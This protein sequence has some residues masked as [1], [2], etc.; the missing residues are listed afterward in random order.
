MA[1]RYPV[2]KLPHSVMRRLLEAH[3]GGTSEDV[4]V[5]PAIGEDAAALQLDHLC[6]VAASDPI[7]FATEAIGY[8]AVHVN[9][10]D[11]ATMGARP[12]WFL[13]TLLIPPVATD[14]EIEKIFVDIASACG[15]IG[16]AWCG[17]HTEICT[18]LPRPLVVG[19][20]LGT[21]EEGRLLCTADAAAGDLLFCTKRVPLEATA[22]I[23]RERREWALRQLGKAAWQR[24]SEL[25][26][27]PGISVVAEAVAA[28]A[29]GDALHDPTEGGIATGLH[30]LADAASVGLEIDFA[31]IPFD[32]DGALLCTA[33]SID[34]LGALASGALLIA[35]P[36]EQA[37]CVSLA[38]ADAGVECQLIGRLVEK[39][40]GR[41]LRRG[42]E[43]RELPAFAVDEVARL[44]GSANQGR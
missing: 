43:R 9:A 11:V 10:N 38:V 34:P 32:P 6:L 16:A 44:F 14:G 3:V 25:L 22:L 4:L 36:P 21:V 24:C 33:A 26:Y 27:R 31:A 7:T 13:A 37:E 42:R 18:D 28:A 41:I 12:R 5:G 1:T 8:Y 39:R 23:A 2:G 29:A 19:T 30:E 17:G 40:A 35:A 15:Q 20:M